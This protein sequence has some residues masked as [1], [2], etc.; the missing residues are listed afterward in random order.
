M[1]KK[2]YILFLV[3]NIAGLLVTV[4]YYIGIQLS[5]K[6]GT[7]GIVTNNK[8][9][10]QERDIQFDTYISKQKMKGNISLVLIF[11]Q[12]II[13]ILLIRFIKKE[14]LKKLSSSSIE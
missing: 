6:Y 3:I 10:E 2:L 4:N 12:I 1:K 7:L 8:I 5:Y 13:F 14:S 11:L 9:S